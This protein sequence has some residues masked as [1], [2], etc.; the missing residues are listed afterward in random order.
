MRLLDEEST[1]EE[2]SSTILMDPPPRKN[3]EKSIAIS[4]KRKKRDSSVPRLNLGGR[5][6]I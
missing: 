2:G 5:W 6:K 4:P 3:K 1:C